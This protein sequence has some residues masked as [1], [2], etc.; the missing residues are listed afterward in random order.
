MEL[1]KNDLFFKGFDV[2]SFCDNKRTFPCPT[3]DGKS[4]K[5]LFNFIKVTSY[6]LAPASATTFSPQLFLPAEVLDIQN[7]S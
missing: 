3:D 5:K 6:K 7:F 4:E 2:G 1:L